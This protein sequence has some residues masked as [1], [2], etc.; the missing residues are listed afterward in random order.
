VLSYDYLDL[1]VFL[2]I[3]VFYRLAGYRILRNIDPVRSG[4]VVLL[5]GV[6]PRIYS[7]FTGVVHVYDYVK[8]HLF[9][10]ASYFPSASTI[11]LV[12]VSI[13][14][15]IA[16]SDSY[17]Y[18]PGY[19]PVIPQI[20]TKNHHQKKSIRS[21]LHISN[22]KPMGFDFFQHQLIQLAR[23]G[24]V[25]IYGGK[26]DKVDIQASSLT[27]YSANK[28][29]AKASHCYGLM[30]P[31]QRGSSLSGRM[32]QAPLHGCC[33]LSEPS[34]NIFDCPGVFEIDDY[35]Q[36]VH[37]LPTYGPLLARQARDFWMTKTSCLAA[38]LNLSLSFDRL[39]REVLFARSILYRQHLVSQ[40]DLYIRHP[41]VYLFMAFRS[42]VR[43]LLR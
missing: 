36:S 27:Y 8:E 3:Y 1:D 21:P 32:W 10:Y 23:L 6:P 25:K 33:V 12:S 38:E 20:W 15:E 5:R 41:F 11:Y 9:D 34:T 16:S 24:L 40:W 30:Y 4:L 43:R 22:Y 31:Y 37:R 39:G 2:N 42:K 18:I 19:L 7:D 35:L 13:S 17:V 29:L 26:W 14:P 28:L